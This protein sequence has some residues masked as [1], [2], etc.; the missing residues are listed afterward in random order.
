MLCGGLQIAAHSQAEFLEMP[1]RGPLRY[2]ALVHPVKLS[3]KN[4]RKS[5]AKTHM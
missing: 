3:L 1:T 2:A 4:K 5:S